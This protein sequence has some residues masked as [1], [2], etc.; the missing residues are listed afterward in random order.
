M[1]QSKT[2]P[3]HN[4]EPGLLCSGRYTVNFTQCADASRWILSQQISSFRCT[5][6]EHTGYVEGTSRC[7]HAKLAYVILFFLHFYNRGCRTSSTTARPSEINS[8]LE[9]INKAAF[10]E[11]VVSVGVRISGVSG[12]MFWWRWMEG[13]KI[14]TKSRAQRTTSWQKHLEHFA[15]TFLSS[16]TQRGLLRHRSVVGSN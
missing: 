14:K 15:S 5:Q 7:L 16:L 6:S 11:S 10:D 1:R 13:G 2:Q 12:V 4:E 9:S 8:R 3:G